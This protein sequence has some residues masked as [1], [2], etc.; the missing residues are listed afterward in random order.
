MATND[1]NVEQ[2]DRTED[3]NDPV[4]GA[5]IGSASMTFLFPTEEPHDVWVHTIRSPEP[6][7][8]KRMLD[9]IC[10]EYDCEYIRFV[11]VLNDN[12]ESKL[13]GA[14]VVEETVPEPSPYAGETITCVDVRWQV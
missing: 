6:N 1:V 14:E 5:D 2:I 7:G 13:D 12:I 10:D 3:T 4:F 8:M 11:N 9:H